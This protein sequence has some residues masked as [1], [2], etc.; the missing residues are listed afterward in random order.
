[1]NSGKRKFESGA[2]KRKKKERKEAAARAQ[3]GAMDRFVVKQTHINSDDAHVDDAV[4]AEAHFT[5][6]DGDVDASTGNEGVGAAIGDD[7]PI[8]DEGVDDADRKSVV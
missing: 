5:E 7:G 6:L 8:G 2:E 4:E 3:K 1:M